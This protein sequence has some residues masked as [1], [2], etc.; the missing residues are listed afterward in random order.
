MPITE[1]KSHL[2]SR[3][4]RRS[5]PAA[6]EFI[7]PLPAT[8][9]SRPYEYA[10]C[11]AFAR[12]SDVVLDAACGISH[13]LKFY[14][15]R[16]CRAAYACDLD[17]RIRDFGDVLAEIR[18]DIGEAAALNVAGE[19]PGP[20]RFAQADITA[21]PY[22]AGKFDT[23][24]CISVLEHLRPEDA[25]RALVEFHRILAQD[26]SLILTLDYPTVNLDFFARL[27]GETG[28]AF[29]GGFDATLPADALHS[30]LWGDLYVFRAALRKR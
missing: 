20:H 7:Y 29:Q 13:P 4:I 12:S 27:V 23:V 19:F 3:F 2:E 25:A 22:E 5:D 15:E 11:S 1:A 16:Q 30:N 26:G 6:R 18:T 28:F 24:F 9:W 21:L 14:L 10:W 8:W 17:A